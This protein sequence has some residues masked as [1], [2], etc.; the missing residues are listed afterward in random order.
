M[1]DRRPSYRYK[2]TY[3]M[4]IYNWHCKV[5]NVDIEVIRTFDDYEKP[6]TVQECADAGLLDELDHEPNWERVI[7]KVNTKKGYRWGRGK[8]HW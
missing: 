8:G 5:N 4:P 1:A 2:E 6:P 3:L 7:S